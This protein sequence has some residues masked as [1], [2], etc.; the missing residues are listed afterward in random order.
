MDQL[1]Q[2][3]L[4]LGYR[5]LCPKHGH[6]SRPAA[7]AQLRSII[8][9]QERAPDRKELVTLHVYPCRRKE[10]RE[11]PWHVGHFQMSEMTKE[12]KETK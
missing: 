8:K 3:L 9:A 12:S 6:R 5:P 10:C 11:A 1:R 2:A 4:D 7:E